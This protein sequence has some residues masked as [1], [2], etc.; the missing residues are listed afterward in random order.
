MGIERTGL[1]S[2]REGD[3]LAMA[4]AGALNPLEMASLSATAD[5]LRPLVEAT[6]GALARIEATGAAE[7]GLDPATLPAIRRVDADRA[8]G[9]A[10][11]FGLRENRDYVVTGIATQA[12]MPGWLLL[13]LALAL[14]AA[15]WR[16]E[17]R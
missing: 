6:G 7:T 4:A 1:Y 11:W 10:D 17:S 12:L 16:R 9:G 13:V 5:R 3:R 2:V 14:M 15:A 8:A